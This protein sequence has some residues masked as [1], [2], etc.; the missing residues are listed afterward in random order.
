MIA[1]NCE[2][3]C[4]I[5]NDASVKF[6]SRK[7]YWISFDLKGYSTI[8]LERE[9]NATVFFCSILHMSAE[10]QPGDLQDA[11]QKHHRL[12]QDAWCVG[13]YS[14]LY[15]SLSETNAQ[16]RP[17]K[18]LSILYSESPIKNLLAVS[19][20]NSNKSNGLCRPHRDIC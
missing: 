3:P 2:I 7:N 14:I 9:R 8:S 17:K 10:T 11:S 1:V 5:Q 20:P 19:R 16:G 4:V 12:C 6:A 15:T 18:N 13:L